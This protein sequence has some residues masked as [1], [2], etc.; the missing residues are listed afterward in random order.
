VIR[1]SA[2]LTTHFKIKADIEYRVPHHSEIPSPRTVEGQVTPP[3]LE[4]QDSDRAELASAE[5]GDDS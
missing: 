1:L 4:S 3:P 2:D 5:G